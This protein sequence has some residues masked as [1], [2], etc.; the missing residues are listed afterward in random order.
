MPRRLA[1]ARVLIADARAS[2]LLRRHSDGYSPDEGSG[3]ECAIGRPASR[4][5][6]LVRRQGVFRPGSPIRTGVAFRCQT[7][8][9]G[10]RRD[11]DDDFDAKLPTCRSKLVAARLLRGSLSGEQT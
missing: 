11:V 7:A 5:R 4:D 10:A 2:Q 6:R 8:S 1:S 9:T 3:G